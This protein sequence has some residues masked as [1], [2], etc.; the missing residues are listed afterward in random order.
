M[1]DLSVFRLWQTPVFIRDLA[2]SHGE[3]KVERVNRDLLTLIGADRET[4]RDGQVG[5]IGAVKSNFDLLRTQHDAV[6]WLRQR[7]SEAVDSL[8]RDTFGGVAPPS[9]MEAVAEAWAVTYLAGG[10]HRMHTHHDVGWSG[11][12][13]VQTDGVGD[14]A[15]HL[16]VLDPRPAAIA[17]QAT[18]AVRVIR[19]KSGLIVAFPGWLAHSAQATLH[20][21]GPRVC[22]PF[23]VGYREV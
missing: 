21:G 7:I 15:G 10:S 14:N 23:N 19:P 6:D 1:T 22:V 16:Q 9:A 17:R 13:Y 5:V 2:Q 11:V 12:Y 3:E 20:D 18:G 4:D 8:M